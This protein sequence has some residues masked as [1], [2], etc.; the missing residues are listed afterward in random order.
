MGNKKIWECLNTFD[1]YIYIYILLKNAPFLKKE[2]FTDFH[3]RISELTS[4][5]VKEVPCYVIRL[6][7]SWIDVMYCKYNI[8]TYMHAKPLA[9]IC[10]KCFKFTFI[11]FF[12]VCYSCQKKFRRQ[13]SAVIFLRAPLFM[14]ADK[15]S[16]SNEIRI[17]SEIVYRLF[18]LCSLCCG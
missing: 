5:E 3:S 16:V 6:P 11:Y 7:Q 4:E 17:N 15:V 1:W 9:H 2:K 8:H 18:L 12:V 10:T 14:M 13:T